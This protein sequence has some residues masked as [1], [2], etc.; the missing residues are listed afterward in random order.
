M[1]AQSTAFY[2]VSNWV[3][4]DRAMFEMYTW[5]AYDYFT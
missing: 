5:K 1:G 4:V 2:V 3:C